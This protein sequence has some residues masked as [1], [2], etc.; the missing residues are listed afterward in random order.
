MTVI[1]FEA[2]NTPYAVADRSPHGP[3]INGILSSASSNADGEH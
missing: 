3:L 2:Q 1:Q